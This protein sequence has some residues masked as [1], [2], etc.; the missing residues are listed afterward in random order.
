MLREVS[1]VSPLIFENAGPECF[2]NKKCPQGD[3]KCFDRMKR[4]WNG[5]VKND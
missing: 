2:M 3:L 5:G 1:K 4:V